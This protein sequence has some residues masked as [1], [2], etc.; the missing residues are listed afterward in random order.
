MPYILRLPSGLEVFR[1]SR[2]APEDGGFYGDARF[3][4]SALRAAF[5]DPTPEQRGGQS[6][7]LYRMPGSRALRFEIRSHTTEE[8]WTRGALM[9]AE[10]ETQDCAVFVNEAGASTFLTAP[11]GQELQAV[12]VARFS[13][14]WTGSGERWNNAQP[15]GSS[16]SELESGTPGYFW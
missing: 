3:F 2:K 16:L 6:G 15:L 7:H 10:D 11:V 13:N 14:T 1:A 8:T 9:L 12:P 4:D 5:P